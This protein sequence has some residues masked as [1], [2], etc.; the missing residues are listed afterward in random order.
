MLTRPILWLWNE[1]PAVTVEVL[2]LLLVAMA[3]ETAGLLA[4]FAAA[5]A[6][7]GS[8]MGMRAALILGALLC[9]ALLVVSV[10]RAFARGM[11]LAEAASD[12]MLLGIV[13]RVRGLEL[14]DLEIV[15]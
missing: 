3:A 10:Y 2:V 4:M 13:E 9:M 1:A 6:E 14:R 11:R 8:S 5:G 12:K 7:T 15:G